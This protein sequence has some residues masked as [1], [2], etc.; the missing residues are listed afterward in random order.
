[1]EIFIGI[2]GLV[3]AI[4]TFWYSFY[5]KPKEELNHLKVQFKAT[6]KLSKD[7]Q[8]ELERYITETNSWDHQMFTNISFGSYL[9]E[10]KES[11]KQNLSDELYDKLDNL[12]LTKSTILS[13]TKSIETQ[14]NALQQIQIEIRM[15]SREING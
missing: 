10:M 5:R 15:R 1:M 13:M 4:L 8:V 14:F 9:T 11:Y 7:L 3:I 12:D 2:L 6:Q